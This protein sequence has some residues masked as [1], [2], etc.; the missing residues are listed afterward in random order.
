MTSIVR[1]PRSGIP[2]PSEQ[3]RPRVDEQDQFLQRMVFERLRQFLPGQLQEPL[4]G[5]IQL[6]TVP[7]NAGFDGE[8][9]SSSQRLFN[10]QFPN[11]HFPLNDFIS[12]Y[13]TKAAQLLHM[14]LGVIRYG[15]NQEEEGLKRPM[16]EAGLPQTF[17]LLSRERPPNQESEIGLHCKNVINAIVSGLERDFGIKD[18][19]RKEIETAITEQ[20]INTY[21]QLIQDKLY[22]FLYQDCKKETSP[23]TLFSEEETIKSFESGDNPSFCFNPRTNAA[24]LY[25]IFERFKKE[26]SISFLSEDLPLLLKFVNDFLDSFNKKLRE[27]KTIFLLNEL[28]ENNLKTFPMQEKIQIISINKDLNVLLNEIKKARA[29]ISTS[30][31]ALCFVVNSLLLDE[32]TSE[33]IKK[34]LP[35]II[36]RVEESIVAFN[37]WVEE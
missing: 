20:F 28:V 24:V 17:T 7:Q 33:E 16:I 19:N 2:R 5:G 30:F 12:F 35:W 37:Q 22:L 10:K 26:H 6:M 18:H 9:L 23:F 3:K 27:D 13:V 25:R 8:F 29:P 4:P 1:P 11:F 21:S 31:D 14:Q 34:D 36:S 32:H 15:K